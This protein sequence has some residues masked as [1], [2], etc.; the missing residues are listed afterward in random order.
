VSGRRSP[1]HPAL[2]LG[3]LFAIFLWGG[4]NAGTKWLLG[5]WP[6][7]WTGS[8]RFLCAG[9]LLLAVLRWTRWLGVPR[10]LTPELRR[11][12]WW[13][14]GLS[15]AAYITVFNCALLFTSA[16]H[17][18]L[19]LG[20]A[21]VWALLWEGWPD[22]SWRSAQRYGAALLALGGVWVLFRP[23]LLDSRAS[24]PGELLGFAASV[25]WTNYGRQCRAL[26]ADLNGAEITAH[27]MW[28]AGLLLLPPG[29]GEIARRGW[30]IG[31]G[32]IGVQLYCILAGGV[33]AFALWNNALRRWPASQV[34]LYNN[35]IPLSTMTWAYFWLGEQFTPTFW[36]AMALIATGVVLGQTRWPPDRA[37]SSPRAAPP[38]RH[39]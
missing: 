20:A 30:V 24:L 27:T 38:P 26:G 23:A 11:R 7:L 10:A 8:T 28:R 12:L 3:L 29:L 6:P 32:Q 19:Y 34:L 31:P 22:R 15:L 25:L 39:N 18:A 33:V 17:V 21:P 1:P 13:R 36:V 35:L 14:G 16:S 37:A 9:L 5:Y 2:A 4:N